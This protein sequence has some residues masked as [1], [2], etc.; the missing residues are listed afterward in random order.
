[1]NTCMY[2]FFT[3]YYTY[4]FS[5][6]RNVLQFLDLGFMQYF[7]QWLVCVMAS[8]RFAKAEQN[9]KVH[10]QHRKEFSRQASAWTKKSTRLIVWFVYFSTCCIFDNFLV[11]SFINATNYF[12][13]HSVSYALSNVFYHDPLQDQ[14]GQHRRLGPNHGNVTV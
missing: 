11:K 6:S 5:F 13:Q 3:L 4:N 9:K 14:L 2:L 10:F 8:L 1:M 12:L 7:K